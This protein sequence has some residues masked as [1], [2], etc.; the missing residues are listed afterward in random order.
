MQSIQN[1]YHCNNDK[2]LALQ[3]EKDQVYRVQVELQIQLWWAEIVLGEG[4]FSL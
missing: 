2:L 4:I 3:L 1:T